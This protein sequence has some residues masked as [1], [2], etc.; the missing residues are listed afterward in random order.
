M[1]LSGSLRTCVVI[2]MMSF[3]LLLHGHVARNAQQPMGIEDRDELL[4]SAVSEESGSAA[5]AMTRVEENL[6]ENKVASTGSDRD[7]VER[8]QSERCRTYDLRRL[9]VLRGDSNGNGNDRDRSL[10]TLPSSWLTRVDRQG[11]LPHA[12]E[13]RESGAFVTMEDLVNCVRNGQQKHG[14][15]RQPV[16][17]RSRSIANQNSYF[18]GA[19]ISDKDLKNR[20]S[21]RRSYW[22]CR[23]L[24][25]RVLPPAMA[26]VTPLSLR[27]C[28]YLVISEKYRFIY[29]A[30][31]KTGSSTI[32]QLLKS[33]FG[34][35]FDKATEDG[36]NPSIPALWPLGFAQSAQQRVASCSL[37]IATRSSSEP[38][39]LTRNPTTGL[40]E[41]NPDD[42]FIFSTVRD[43][44]A[45]F[46]S[47]F[48]EADFQ[49]CQWIEV[50]KEILRKFGDNKTEEELYTERVERMLTMMEVGVYPN[51]HVQ[52]QTSLLGGTD[53]NG[54]QIPLDFIGRLET[55]SPDVNHILRTICDRASSR[56]VAPLPAR[57]SAPPTQANTARPRPPT[58]AQAKAR[59]DPSIA[60]RVCDLFKQDYECFGYPLPKE[61]AA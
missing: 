28:T 1:S 30:N 45:R 32:R 43:P 6:V 2:V 16:P 14:N 18:C 38:S 26:H 61:C 33:V 51:E 29:L 22:P 46:F 19:E 42:F 39:A 52:S 37:T 41:F 56:G 59:G 11:V 12:Q 7:A 53:S 24:P 35:D 31:Y 55:M 40:L 57:C 54:V 17:G 21:K 49:T 5:V 13:I 4:L 48:G 9:E 25:L 50:N 44:M 20:K 10:S 34:A 3:V 60:R 15:T 47:G 8:L 58:E 36:Y 23:V 27:R